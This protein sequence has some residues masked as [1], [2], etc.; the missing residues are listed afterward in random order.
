MTILLF[1]T[2]TLFSVDDKENY[3]KIELTFFDT[4]SM[5]KIL[6]FTLEHS[7]SPC[8]FPSEAIGKNHSLL[9]HPAFHF[10]I[11]IPSHQNKQLQLTLQH[12]RQPTSSKWNYR[13]TMLWFNTNQPSRCSL[14]SRR[15]HFRLHQLSKRIM[16][17][18]FGESDCKFWLSSLHRKHVNFFFQVNF[19]PQKEIRGRE[20]F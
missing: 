5:C 7:F 9:K 17:C 2:G 4:H 16:D 1:Q 10:L 14:H 20:Y 13:L 18:Q 19:F 12:R 3:Q 8:T 11:H 15:K 6:F